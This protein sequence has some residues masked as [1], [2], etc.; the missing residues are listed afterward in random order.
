MT[1]DNGLIDYS[2]FHPDQVELKRYFEEDKVYTVQIESNLACRQGCFFCYASSNEQ[3]DKELPKEIVISVLDS[4]AN[5]GV[6]AIDWLGGDPLERK[7]W[8]ELMKYSMNLGM[9]NNIWTSGLPL[10]ERDIAKKAV[11]VSQGGFISVHLDT[12][13]ERLYKKLH[14]GNPKEKIAAIIKGVDNVLVLGKSSDAMFNCITFTKIL[15]NEDIGQTIRFFYE[16][17]GM[18]TCLTQMCRVGSALEHPE[19]IPT[20]EEIKEAVSIRDSINYPGSLKSMSTMDA[21]KFYCGGAICVTIDGDVT[22]CSVIRK[23]FGNV[24]NLAL[25]T[26]IEKNKAALLYTELRDPKNLPG[27]CRTCKNNDVC[28]GCR[29]T[30]YYEAGDI[31][32]KDPK[33]MLGHN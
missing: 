28:W 3:L 10:A 4:A 23:G 9:K 31:L 24:H 7:D 6:R 32:A 30:A 12:I 20:N 29:A 21:N 11:E 8:Y 27:N 19:W 14:T 1:A 25:E 18:R 15:A 16:K 2:C 22:P 33:C 26:I 5:M 13:D 17:K